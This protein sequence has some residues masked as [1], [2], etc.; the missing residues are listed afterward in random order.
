M[1]KKYKKK[2]VCINCGSS[3]YTTNHKYTQKDVKYCDEVELY[4]RCD[5]CG[6]NGYF[7]Y[8]LKFLL[9]KKI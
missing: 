2:E 5:I 8:E 4:Y 7:V 1:S 6:F 3:E 9:N